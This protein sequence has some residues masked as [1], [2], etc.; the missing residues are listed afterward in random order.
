METWSDLPVGNRFRIKFYLDT[1]ILAYLVDKTYSGLTQ[2]ILYLKDS[3]FADLCSS[4]Y[5]IFE[6]VGVRKREHYLRSVVANSTNSQGTVNMSSLIK[7]RDDFNAPEVNFANIKSNIKETIFQELEEITNNFGIDYETNILH[8]Q[9]LSPTIGVTLSSK[10][11]RHDA[12]MYVSS[13]WTDE[14]LREDFVFLMS[15]DESFVKN[16]EDGDLE[17]ELINF[18][19]N[20]PQVEWLRSMKE[21]NAHKLN[22][23]DS[24]EDHN[25]NTYL[26]NKLKELIIN[27]NKQYFLG[28]TINCGKGDKFPKDV[29]CFTLTENTT[30]NSHIFLI[31]IGK[32][33]DFIYLTKIP[34]DSFWNQTQITD[35][36]FLSTNSTNISFRPFEFDDKENQVQLPQAKLNRLREPGNLI[37]LNPDA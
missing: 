7:Y 13:I 25:L 10:I 33:L 37:F 11:S 9:L 3:E 31:I 4:K 8:N 32:D 19:L 14:T 2:T 30:L 21:N 26:P 20:K 6:F 5:V 28:R 17:D 16:C 27:K 23:T 35:Y 34:I 18:N 29:V 1:N 36:P 15:N 12:L 24:S 22:L